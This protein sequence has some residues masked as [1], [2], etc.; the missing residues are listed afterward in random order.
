[1]LPSVLSPCSA[2][3][4][5]AADLLMFWLDVEQ[6]AAEFAGSLDEYW[7][8]AANIHDRFLQGKASGEAEAEGEGMWL[9]GATYRSIVAKL[10]ARREPSVGLFDQAQRE[11]SAYMERE[12]YPHFLHSRAYQGLLD[13]CREAAGPPQLALL[14]GAEEEST[15][16]GGGGGGGGGGGAV[17]GDGH[18][19]ATVGAAPHVLFGMYL[20][21]TEQRPAYSLYRDMKYKLRG[22]AE[23][24]ARCRLEFA[25]AQRQN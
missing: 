8:C 1:M 21:S 24:A 20:D 13:W 18:N 14:C 3:G 12:W 16:S 22:E 19:G 7:E 10:E 15:G 6:F 9:A 4:C 25:H 17:G 5:G 23:Y 2:V 11:A